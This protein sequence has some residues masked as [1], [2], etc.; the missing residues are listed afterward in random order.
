MSSLV[1][2][3]LRV[4]LIGT[5]KK[6]LRIAERKAEYKPSYSFYLE[7]LDIYNLA[8]L[9]NE[10]LIKRENGLRKTLKVFPLEKYMEQVKLVGYEHCVKFVKFNT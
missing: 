3:S 10:E 4:V 1:S 7:L 6:Y 2:S 9:I 8:E 5:L